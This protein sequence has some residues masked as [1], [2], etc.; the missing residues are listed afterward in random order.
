[1]ESDKF[2]GGPHQTIHIVGAGVSGLYCA[3]QLL[4]SGFS[5]KL[6]DHQSG[7][8][9][10]FLVAGNGGLNLTHSENLS[11]FCKRYGKH[12]DF[13]KRALKVFSP[14][15]LRNWC[16]ELGVET[17]VGTSGRVFPTKL[18]AA[19][20]LL[21]LRKKLESHPQF[22]FHLKNKFLGIKKD[23]NKDGHYFLELEGPQGIFKE[24]AHTIIFALGGGS[25]AKT[26]S[27]GLWVN[28][29]TK[30]GLDIEPLKAM[31]CGFETEWSSHFTTKVERL[32]LKNISLQ[33]KEKTLRTEVMVT[34]YGIEGTGIY[35]LSHD[36]ALEIENVGEATLIIDLKP[37]LSL[38]QILEKISQ[39]KP[40][41]SLNN[42]FRK[43]FGLEK[44]ILS[45]LREFVSSA[46]INNGQ[47][48]GEKLK[49]VEI[50]LKRARPIDEAI[51][52][53]GGIR[54]EDLTEALESKQHKNIFFAGEMLDFEAPTGGYLIQ[55]AISSGH[56]I[57][58]EILKR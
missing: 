26:G 33:F 10:K 48:L 34:H 53:S 46:E 29:F 43:S 32:P 41:E 51:S 45:F 19:E 20:I 38:D 49:R 47:A 2:K 11:D 3:D 9:K 25:W 39:K 1:M 23:P 14:E 58:Q 22:S 4:N 16:H 7:P 42:L 35:A 15:D 28:A 18:K 12:E 40:K 5:V 8:G 6:Y 36:I 13:F 57:C 27:D 21:T 31:N 24:E 52:T 50:K 37:D 56:V 44:D 30:F 17:F 55:G 54:L